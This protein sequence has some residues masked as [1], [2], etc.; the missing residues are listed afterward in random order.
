M[1]K[2][3]KTTRLTESIKISKKLMNSVEGRNE[4][5]D[6]YYKE[7]IKFMKEKCSYMEKKLEI[8][9]SKLSVISEIKNIL[10]DTFQSD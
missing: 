10:K 7:K 2:V 6:N 1:K 9:K 4:V 3:N 8:S 5:L